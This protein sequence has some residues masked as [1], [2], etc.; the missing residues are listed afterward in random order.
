MCHKELEHQFIEIEHLKF[1]DKT[2]TEKIAP[3][4]NHTNIKSHLHRITYFPR[5][6]KKT[7]QKIRIYKVFDRTRIT[8]PEVNLSSRLEHFQLQDGTTRLQLILNLCERYA[9]FRHYITRG[10][11]N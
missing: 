11:Q 5:L 4:R 10:I 2:R 3:Q 8:M 1:D 9:I 7:E 6:H